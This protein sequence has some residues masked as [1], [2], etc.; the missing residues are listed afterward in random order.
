M[1]INLIACVVHYKNRLAIGRNG[2]LLLR[3]S[4][5]MRMFQNITRT[6]TKDPNV[7]NVVLM[8]RKTW[9]SIPREHRPLKGRLNLVLTR[10][11]ELLALSPYP[12]SF[13]GIRSLK[14]DKNV[15]FITYEQFV[16][17]YTKTRRD[18]FVI[19]GGEIY[20]QFLNSDN[21]LLV[22]DNV[23]LTEVSNYK[24]GFGLEP[25]TFMQPP[26]WRYRLVDVSDAHTELAV[27]Y[28]FLR[29][30]RERVERVTDETVYLDT[31]R[32]ILSE[33]NSRG[34]RTGV[35][36]VSIFG[37]QMSFDISETVPLLT[38]KRVPWRSCIEELLWFMRGDTDAKILQ[39]RGVRIWDGNTSREFLDARGL[40]HYSPGILGP[41]YGWQW[42]FFGADYSQAFAD[43]SS[44]DT[45][46]IGGFDQL[47]YVEHLLRTDPFSRRIM[48]SYWNPPDFAKT[49]LV[50]C[51][52]TCQFY[53]TE[54]GEDRYLSCHFVMRSNDM[55]LGN[56]F[57]IFSYAVLTYILAARCG[58][59]PDRL[60]Y[61]GGD[62]H[63]Y[64]NHLEQVT[65]QLGR[66]PRPLPKLVM[67]HEVAT[68]P[69]KEIC[70]EDFNVIGYF[71]HPA[72]RA[73]MAI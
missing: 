50:P 47:A 65:E 28:R 23:Y 56:P 8:G 30:T 71:P 41:G 44:I 67:S 68:K 63:I 38:T 6:T 4:E 72:I 40:H 25:D 58:M 29:Y 57:N 2:S 62:L 19:G 32:K 51:H 17:F 60:V 9:F 53:V 10:D 39:K 36:T 46:K 21:D 24:P 35:G 11:P 43:T 13:C 12:K 18:V 42:R 69:I 45:S 15:Y 1:T 54:R 27:N 59:K 14:F 49:A 66:T 34:D 5:D 20:Q 61:S 52:F 3:L 37:D 73:P 70:V 16:D 22:P 48:M 55:F 33:G 31:L 7:K 64:K 26:D